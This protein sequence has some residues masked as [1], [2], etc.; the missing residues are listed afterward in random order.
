ME[1]KKCEQKKQSSPFL[2]FLVLLAV[3]MPG[4]TG[5]GRAVLV[6]LPFCEI[7]P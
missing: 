5:H 6:L 7:Q 2:L 3:K 4:R 1:K